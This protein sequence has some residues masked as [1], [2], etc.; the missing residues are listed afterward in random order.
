MVALSTLSDV[1]VGIL[2]AL[3][4]FALVWAVLTR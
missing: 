1:V 4:A 2:I 3:L